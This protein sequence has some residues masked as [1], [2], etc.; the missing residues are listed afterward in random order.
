MPALYGFLVFFKYTHK[1][2]ISSPFF[3]AFVLTRE[4]YF[5]ILMYMKTFFLSVLAFFGY[6][7][8]SLVS[9]A[10]SD[11]MCTMEYAPVCAKVQVQCIRAPCY[12]IYETFSNSCVMSQN[13]QAT[14]V[15]NGECKSS[16]TGVPAVLSEKLQNSLKRQYDAFVVHISWLSVNDRIA[17]L[18]I[19]DS[20]IKTR[21]ATFSINTFPLTLVQEMQNDKMKY[22]LIFLQNLVET[23]I[24]YLT[25]ELS[26][27][28][29]I[30]KDANMCSNIK[31]YCSTTEI[32]FFNDKGCG[33]KK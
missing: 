31:F 30:S 17:R 4:S 25:D 20:R 18:E 14:L 9:A 26:G 8:V 2:L 6:M 27:M 22:A 19:I 1:K 28:R 10:S 29:Y 16:E 12:P 21:L 24:S 5:F 3:R 7:T 15:H 23:D 11:F 32:P 13:S 33:C